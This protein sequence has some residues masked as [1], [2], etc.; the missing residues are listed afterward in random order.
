M[1]LVQYHKLIRLEPISN[2]N[3]LYAQ[4]YT[5]IHEQSDANRVESGS[6]INLK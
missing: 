1:F 6:S 5:N 2:Q 4:S 3:S